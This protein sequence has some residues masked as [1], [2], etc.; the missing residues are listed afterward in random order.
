MY[1]YFRNNDKCSYRTTL[2]CADSSPR[3]DGVDVQGDPNGTVADGIS[4]G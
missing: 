1:F 3:Y 2:V 4:A